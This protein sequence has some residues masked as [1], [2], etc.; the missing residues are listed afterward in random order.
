MK[1]LGIY[2]LLFEILA[3]GYV[4]AGHHQQIE[5]L[6]HKLNEIKTNCVGV[7]VR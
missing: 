6:E 5:I 4:S 3:S 1:Y 7:R 2:I